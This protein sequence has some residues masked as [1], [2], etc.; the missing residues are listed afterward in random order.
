MKRSQISW[1]KQEQNT[2]SKTSMNEQQII[3]ISVRDLVEFILREGDIDNRIAGGMDRNAMQLG[4][5]MHRK[6]QQGMGAAYH[7]EVPLK[8]QIPL[9]GFLLQVEG[10]ADGIIEEKD[11]VIIDE[12]K[13]VM[14]DLSLT[15]QPI[16]VHLAQARCYAYIYLYS[17]ESKFGLAQNLDDCIQSRQVPTGTS[18]EVYSNE[19]KFGLDRELTTSLKVR[20][21]YCQLETEEIKYF[22]EEEQTEEL[23]RWFFELVHAYEKWAKFQLEWRKCRNASIKQIKFPFAYREGQKQLATAV[24]RTISREKLLFVQAP[25]GVGKTIATVFPAVKAVGEEL[26]EKIFYL[27]AKTITRTVAEQ[28]FSVLREQGL[29]WRSLTLTAKEKICFCEETNCNPEACPYAKGHF[30]RVNNAVYELLTTGEKLDRTSVEEQARKHRVCPFEMSLD[31]SEWVD[32]VICD[33]NYVFDPTARLKR[34]FSENGNEKKYIFLIDEAHN[35][36][37][38]GREMYSAVL[39]KEDF[40]EIRKLVQTEDPRLAKR[41]GECNKSLLELKRTCETYEIQEN[42][43]QVILKLMNLTSELER[44]L[45]EN[46]NPEKEIL[47]FFF[48]L[49]AFLDI[50]DRVD[51]NYVVYTELE[52]NGKFKLKLYCVNPAVNLRESLAYGK[53]AIFFSATFLPIHY[54]KKL[55]SVNS[56]D[57]A[58]YAKSPFLEENKIL[59]IGK[60]VSTKYTMRSPEMYR[61]IADQILR[62]A[63]IK[64]GNYLVFFPSHRVLEEVYKEAEELV[65]ENER[66][67]EIGA[68]TIR[69]FRQMP[70]MT[71]A[72]REDFLENF[73]NF[74]ASGNSEDSGNSGDHGTPENQ[75][76]LR[77][78][79]C[80][81]GGIFAEGIDLPGERLIGAVVVGTGLPQVCNE[82]EILKQYFDEKGQRGFDYAY[83]YPGMNKVLQAAGRVIRTEKDKGMILLLDERFLQRNYREIFPREWSRFKTGKTEVLLQ[84]LDDFWKRTENEENALKEKPQAPDQK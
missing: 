39:Y 68:E 80:V 76:Q 28:A 35:L 83:L 1:Q 23:K 5:K 27:T 58:V 42:I 7:A 63:R 9:D 47:D 38:R 36:V 57:Y 53:S 40:L 41:L 14:R 75:N 79:F 29:Q 62:A 54:Y 26:G 67:G 51:E 46:E 72:E 56:D 2:N 37:E 84:E 17:N 74:R 32:S 16:G 6:I 18:G 31:L 15:T 20:M 70:Y 50:Y 4:N 21:T 25:T 73:E 48:A 59:L 71:E 78:G 49:R 65:E 43:L 3:K 22:M 34:F 45:E 33:Y 82:R 66:S 60:E 19:S 52:S 30:D 69:M 24:Y 81:L 8:M 61:R 10:R 13:G 11:G 55:L 44:Y 77:L 64:P 12:I